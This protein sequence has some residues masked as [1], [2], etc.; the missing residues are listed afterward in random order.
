MKCQCKKAG[1]CE[2]HKR[3][4]SEDMHDLCQRSD[5]H[6]A[7]FYA[8]RDRRI[9]PVIKFRDEASSHRGLGDTI[10]AITTATGIKS[11]M[12][13]LSRRTG[14]KCGCSKRRDA[15]NQAVPYSVENHNP[16]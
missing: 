11:L 16:E 15:L 5:R 1:Y 9:K 14:R 12:I 2:Q 13:W 4:M 6:F 7:M 8:Q 10:E 3:T